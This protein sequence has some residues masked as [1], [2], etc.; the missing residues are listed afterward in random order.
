V[1]AAPRSTPSTGGHDLDPGVV[2]RF[3]DRRPQ[4]LVHGH[5]PGPLPPGGRAA[6]YGEGFR[7]AAQP[8]GEVVHREQPL[9]QVRVLDL[10]LEVIKHLDLAV[11]QR[12]HPHGQV[13]QDFD[14]LLVRTPAVD[15]ARDLDYP[16]DRLVLPLLDIAG[17]GAEGVAARHTD[18]RRDDRRQL[19]AARHSF[20]HPLQLGLAALRNFPGIAQLS[21]HLPAR[22]ARGDD[23]RR[24]QDQDAT[25]DTRED[26]AEHARGRVAKQGDHGRHHADQGDRSRREDHPTQPRGP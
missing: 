5:L 25:G 8:G 9:E 24:E 18:G 7:L 16:Q 12:L 3:G 4:H 23:R 11:N 14:P 17:E 10:R 13:H 26:R 15:H 19:L 2:L 22:G 6:E 20:D 21:V 1:T